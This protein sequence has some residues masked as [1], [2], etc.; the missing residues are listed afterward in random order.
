MIDVKTIVPVIILSIVGLIIIYLS[1][2]VKFKKQAHLIS[3]YN[4]NEVNDK[5]G[6]CNWFGGV[7]MI[8][9]FYL[10]F[11]GQLLLFFEPFILIIIISIILVTVAT[12]FIAISGGKKFKNKY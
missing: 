3:G 8:P 7:L 4:E 2:L 5:I 12:V 10:I 1:Y 6:F 11:A 9:G